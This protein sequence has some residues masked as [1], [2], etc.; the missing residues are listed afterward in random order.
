MIRDSI[1]RY[2][3]IKLIKKVEIKKKAA[4]LSENLEPNPKKFISR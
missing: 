1:C 3:K 2:I 4:G